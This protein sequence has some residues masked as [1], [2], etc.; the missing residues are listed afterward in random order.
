MIWKIESFHTITSMFNSTETTEGKKE[1]EEILI[2][3]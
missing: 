2:I 1:M 3:Y